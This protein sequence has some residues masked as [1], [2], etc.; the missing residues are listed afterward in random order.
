MLKG[1]IAALWDRKE[2]P[3]AVIPETVFFSQWRFV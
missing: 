3:E 2:R 1:I